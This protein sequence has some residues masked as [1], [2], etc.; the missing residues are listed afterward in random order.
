MKI[1]DA[2][3]LLGCVMDLKRL[4]RKSAT[5]KKCR[6]GIENSIAQNITISLVKQEKW[7]QWLPLFLESY[8]H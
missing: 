6:D 4:F 1:N 8:L 5:N 3:T 2:A 7:K